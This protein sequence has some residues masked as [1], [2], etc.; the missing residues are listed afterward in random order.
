MD[1]LINDKI[2]LKDLFFGQ[3]KNGFIEFFRSL[4]V[5]G[6]AFVADFVT[7]A[8]LKELAGMGTILSAT[9]GFAV[10]VT[11]NYLMSVFWAFRVSNVKNAVARFVIFLAIA[12]VGL[13][14]NNLIIA[15]FDGY[16][17]RKQIF[18]TLLDPAR[19]YMAGKVIAT[20]VVF[21]WNFFSRKLLLFRNKAD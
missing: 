16:F 8:L 10:G 13:L 9:L 1:R 14:I 12:A 18:G 11:V 15:V 19:Y 4:F 6:A 5:G 3:S 7:L 2:K 17:A 21:F 20:V